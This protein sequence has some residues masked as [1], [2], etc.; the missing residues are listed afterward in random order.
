[1]S[2]QPDA[3]SQGLALGVAVGFADSGPLGWAIGGLITVLFA[4]LPRL[5][6]HQKT[7]PKKNNITQIIQYQMFGDASHT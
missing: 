6:E 3:L 5:W 4:I 1:M 7:K 2:E